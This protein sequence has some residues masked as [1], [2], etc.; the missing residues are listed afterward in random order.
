MSTHTDTVPGMPA[1]GAGS[2]RP[3]PV[4]MA[5]AP[6][7]PKSV[8]EAGLSL[9]FLQDLALRFLYYGGVASGIELAHEMC[10]PWSGVVSEVVDFMIQEKQVALSGGKG[11]G[12]ASVDFILTERGREAARE[13]LLRTTYT[14][15]APVPMAAY[16]KA[17]RD[18]HASFTPPSRA[19][20]EQALAHLVLEPGFV[21][22][23]G[24]A[25]RASRSLFLYG[26]PGNGK[27]SIAESLAT[28][29][30]GQI[31]IPN[32]VEI[33]GQVIKIFDPIAHREI[34]LD[35][36]SPEGS[37]GQLDRRW[38]LSLRPV[39]IAGGELTLET[40]DLIW[41]RDTRFYEAPYQMKANGGL[42]LIDDF[43]RQRVH[44]TDLL[45]RWIVPLE[46][47]VDYLTLHTGKKFE[48]PFDELVVFS[49]NLDPIDLVDDAFLRRIKYKIEVGDP[50]EAAYRQIFQRGCESLGVPFDEGALDYILDVWYRQPGQDLRACHPRDLLQILTDA[51]VYRG[52]APVLSRDLVDHACRSFLVEM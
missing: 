13:A 35:G 16:I 32:A 14:G 12:R 41:N 37:R 11:F 45:N 50:S 10:L 44:P 42:L 31:F 30:K 24:P 51:A 26:P 28:A 22:R 4:A 5:L 47:H 18:Q 40:L 27:T 17:L 19:D 2:T 25:L 6:P 29:L 49:T 39:V 52:A 20:L 3:D 15:P 33:D 21:D 7:E 23:V 38:R 48:V 36:G 43:G 1:L 46:K 8:E 9:G 34:P